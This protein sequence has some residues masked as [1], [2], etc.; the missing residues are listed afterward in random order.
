[1]AF[2]IID[3]KKIEIAQGQSFMDIEEAAEIP[4]ACRA[5]VCQTCAVTI[6]SGDEKL[7]ALNDNEMMMGAEGAHRLAC[8]LSCTSGDAEV[9]I[10]LGW[11]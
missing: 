1:M 11:N 2:V 5:G 7:P 9:E 4:F 6:K 3:G 10:E 8:Q